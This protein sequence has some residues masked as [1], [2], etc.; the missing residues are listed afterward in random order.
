MKVLVMK[1]TSD[2]RNMLIMEIWNR[3]EIWKVSLKW[4]NI[5]WSLTSLLWRL[6]AQPVLKGFV[7]QKANYSYPYNFILFHA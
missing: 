6:K 3:T 1:L 2:K 5:I 7:I 4:K